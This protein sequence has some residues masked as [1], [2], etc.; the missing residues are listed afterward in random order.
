M[1]LFEK[2]FGSKKMP[3]GQGP[4]RTLTAYVPTFSTFSGSLYESELVRS[5]IDARARHISKLKV[6]AVGTGKPHLQTL[7]RQGPNG[8]QTWSQFLYRL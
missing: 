5:A 6:E 7:L 2:I 4:W 8:F 1:G 3:V